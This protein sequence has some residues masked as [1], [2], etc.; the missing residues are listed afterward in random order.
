MSKLNVE[1]VTPSSKVYAGEA[2]MV[3]VPGVSGSLGFLPGHVGLVTPLGKGKVSISNSDKTD[4]SSAK[5]FN[6]EGGYVQV[7]DD[8]VVVLAEHVE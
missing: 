2:Y 5:H 7:F 1:I 4:D 8:N 3:S 6:I